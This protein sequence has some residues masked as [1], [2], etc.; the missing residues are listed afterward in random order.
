MKKGFISIIIAAIIVSFMSMR[1]DD[2]AG[3]QL[4]AYSVCFY[5]LENLF[6]T[7]H[8]EGK[9]DYEYLPDGTNKWGS[10]KYTNKLKNMAQVLYLVAF[11]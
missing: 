8:D 2:N 10:M 3:K 4:Q 6:D 5:N 7:I 9:N 1:P 11:F